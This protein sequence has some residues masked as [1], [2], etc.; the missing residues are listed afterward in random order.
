MSYHNGK[1]LQSDRYERGYF[2]KIWMKYYCL[3]ENCGSGTL[4]LKFIRCQNPYQLQNLKILSRFQGHK[5][6]YELN[7]WK[8]VFISEKTRLYRYHQNKSYTGVASS[9]YLS[10]TM[11]LLMKSHLLASLKTGQQWNLTFFGKLFLTF[12]SV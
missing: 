2:H 6:P 1:K 7:I 5:I 12:S 11:K 4:T 9:T 10:L 8:L 3:G